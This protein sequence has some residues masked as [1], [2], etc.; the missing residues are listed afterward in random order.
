MFW[1]NLISE[2]GRIYTET[3]T[4]S[5]FVCLTSSDEDF[6]CINTGQDEVRQTKSDEDFVSIPTSKRRI[7][8]EIMSS[9]LKT[10][11]V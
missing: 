6:V 9:E 7:N 8:W 5:D 4:S 11:S 10:S 3:K 1:Q 2:I